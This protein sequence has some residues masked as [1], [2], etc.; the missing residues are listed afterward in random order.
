MRPLALVGVAAVAVGFVAVANRGIA[1]A[2]DPSTV[3][4]TLVGALAVAQGVRYANERRGR[5]RRI[6]DPGEPERRAPATVPGSDLDERIARTTAA[7]L[8]GYASRRELRERIRTAAVAA[9]ARDRNCSTGAADRAVAVGTW[10]DD[11]TAA[12]FLSSDA[13]YPVRTRLRAALRGRSRYGYGL[14]AAI[15]AIGRLDPDDHGGSD[16]PVGSDDSDGPG[17]PDT[18]GAPAEAAR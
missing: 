4:V 16:G 12:A 2:I 3:V 17:G 10:T 9:V 11:P 6:A 13:S 8:G 15:D 5:D 1:A 18:P 14:R 7:S